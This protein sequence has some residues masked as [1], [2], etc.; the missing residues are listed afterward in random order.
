[1]AFAV[2]F[3]PTSVGRIDVPAG[4]I[5]AW[6][7]P[8]SA[9]TTTICHTCNLSVSTSMVNVNARPAQITLVPISKLRRLTRSDT[10]PPQGSSNTVGMPDAKASMPSQASEFVIRKISHAVAT[11]WAQDPTLLAK[12]PIQSR[13]KSRCRKADR[14]LVNF[15]RAVAR[16]SF[17]FKSS[18]D[19]GSNRDLLSAEN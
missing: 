6:A 18:A 5:S 9:D 19:S 14:P 10:T 15:E 16:A 8:D 17:D 2:F 4:T 12:V 7:T 13:R 11:F 3:S 1:M